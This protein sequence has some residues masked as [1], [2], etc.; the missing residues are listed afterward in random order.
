MLKYTIAV[1]NREQDL[2][3]AI[4]AVRFGEIRGATVEH[5]A[6]QFQI[7]VSE[8]KRDLIT[9]IRNGYQHF[10]AIQVHQGEP[11]YAEVTG[12]E[13]GFRCRKKI[14]FPTE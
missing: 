1:S 13:F 8:N 10:E 4:E 9:A 3:D 7:E 6:A 2:L 14:K 5:E 11:V 12:E